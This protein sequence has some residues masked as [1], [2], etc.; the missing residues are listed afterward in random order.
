MSNISGFP[1][2]FDA[3]AAKTP[4][5]VFSDVDGTLTLPPVPGEDASEIKL[6]PGILETFERI[7]KAGGYVVITSA[8]PLGELEKIFGNILNVT[9]VANDGCV[10]KYQGNV[11]SF[12][13]KPDF[14]AAKAAANAFASAHTSGQEVSIKSADMDYFCGIFVNNGHEQYGDAYAT[15]K[16]FAIPGLTVVNKHHNGVTLEPAD[17][18]GKEGLEDILELL[19]AP[20]AYCV[21]TGDGQNDVRAQ[22]LVKNL[23]G[24]SLKVVSSE[25]Q[26]P[27]EYVN[28]LLV[29]TQECAEFYRGLADRMEG[30]V[31]RD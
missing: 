6:V 1:G 11:T 20:K 24:L 13:G 8:R 22:G 12:V 19:S 2:F 10:A 18:P 17:K 3:R 14:T 7:A 26:E 23:G 29:G 21:F 25:G 27:P 28:G 31:A 5:V 9:L 15:L 16:R 4:I 30:P